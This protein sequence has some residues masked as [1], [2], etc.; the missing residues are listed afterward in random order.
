M[1]ARAWRILAFA[2]SACAGCTRSEQIIELK[3]AFSDATVVAELRPLWTATGE[4]RAGA[5]GM[6]RRFIL[7]IDAVNRL[8]EPIHLRLSDLRVNGGNAAVGTRGLAACA[9]APGLTRNVMQT[10][11]WLPAEAAAARAIE[12]DSFALP[13]SERGRAFYR[14]FLLQRRPDAA[15]AIDAEIAAAAAVPACATQ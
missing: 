11:V 6:E 5:Q 14:E 12:I 9:L 10:D 15:A 13:L 7:H 2:L 4:D 3:A 1:A 8:S